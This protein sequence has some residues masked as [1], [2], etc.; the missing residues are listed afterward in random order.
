MLSIREQDKVAI[1]KQLER[2]S[3]TV[4]TER[5]EIEKSTVSNIKKNLNKILHF[6]QEMCDMGMSKKASDESWR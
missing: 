5:Y 4:I 6:K 3:A 1:I 2:I